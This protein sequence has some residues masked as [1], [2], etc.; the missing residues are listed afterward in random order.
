MSRSSGKSTLLSRAVQAATK[1]IPPTQ[2]LC[3]AQITGQPPSK[4]TAQPA[5]RATSGCE[6]QL[7]KPAAAAVAQETKTNHPIATVQTTF[8]AVVSMLHESAAANSA[9]RTLRGQPVLRLTMDRLKNNAHIH[10]IRVLC[11]ADQEQNVHRA[12]DQFIGEKANIISVDIK[13]NRQ[14]IICMDAVGIAR[15]WTNG[16][17][18]GLLQTCA[19]DHGFYAKWVVETVQQLNVD[20]AV[21]IDPAAGF[22]DATLLN[23]L[24]EH[25]DKHVESPL[26]FTQ[27][28]PGLCG[29]VL[30]KSLL[31]QLAS[32]NLH[33]GKFLHYQPTQPTRDPISDPSCLPVPTSVARSPHRFTLDSDRQI[34]LIEAAIEHVANVS[35]AE[36]ERPGFPRSLADVS[37]EQ[38]IQSMNASDS[39]RSIARSSPREIVVEITTRRIARPIFLPDSAGISRQDLQ[40][41]EV[42]S[43]FAEIAQIDDIHLILAGVGDP[44]LHPQFISI[45]QQARQAGINSIHIRTDLLEL[46]QEL[47]EFLTTPTGPDRLPPVDI[48]SVHIPAVSAVVYKQLMQVDGLSRV[49]DNVR[50]MVEMKWSRQSPGPIIVPVFTKCKDNLGEMDVWYDRWLAAM[51]SAVIAGASDFAGQIADHSPVDMTPPNRRGCNRLDSRMHILS[52]GTIVACEQDFTGLSPIAKIRSL[53]V[54]QAWADGIGALRSRHQAGD[55]SAH[56]LCGKCKDW[57]R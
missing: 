42:A 40:L 31:V 25:A 32:A 50:R 7:A 56:P 57:H 29:T 30:R 3:T 35:G 39:L 54:L 24:L 16:W 46:P 2:G 22:L 23:Q 18:G 44:L 26:I 41:T 4:P 51:G 27:A 15:K 5:S 12:I 33:A 1:R 9:T 48:V 20:A 38:L 14:P 43:L 52:D 49:L 47:L 10:A 55:I 36:D 19:F 28:A 45:I 11:W 34:R 13:G 6:S 53:P 21:L 37:A 8:V 17:R